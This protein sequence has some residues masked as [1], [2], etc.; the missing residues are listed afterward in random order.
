[1]LE[2]YG[3][4]RGS[5]LDD[6]RV[7]YDRL[8]Q[9]T[10]SDSHPLTIAVLASLIFL[11]A[12]IQNSR[13]VVQNALYKSQSLSHQITSKKAPDRAP[14][15][16]TP[17]DFKR[18][19]TAPYPDWSLDATKPLPYRPFRWGPYHITMGLR[20]MKWDE[21]IEL[22]NQFLKFHDTKEGRIAERGARCCKTAP[23]AYDGACELLEELCVPLVAYLVQQVFLGER[24]ADQRAPHDTAAA[25]TCPSATH[26]CTARPR[27]AWTT[28]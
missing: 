26:R 21:W 15:T 20:S 10:I 4:S 7:E 22:D 24:F 27:S 2:T 25:T 6:A 12:I 14:G 11:F 5:L 16:W 17:V 23:E 1:M 28:S 8:F 13:N 19:T 18:P 3:H 9:W